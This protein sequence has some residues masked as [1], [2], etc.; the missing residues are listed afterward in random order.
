MSAAAK[1]VVLVIVGHYVPGFKA[2]GI[3]RSVENMVNH[4]HRE[5]QF[6]IVTRDRDIGD[7]APYPD[8]KQKTWNTIGNARVYYLAPGTESVSQLR[9][10]VQETAHDLIYFNSFFDPL[11]VK[12]L[13]N[14]RLGHLGRKPILLNP[15]GEFGWA[16]LSQKYPKKALFMRLAQLVGLYT[17]VRWHASSTFEAEDIMNA[18]NIPRQSIYIALDLP[19][20]TEYGTD[21]APGPVSD[22][23][24]DGIRVVFLS[25]IAPEKNLNF[26]L[27]VL[28]RVRTKV[29]FDIIGPIENTACWHECQILVRQLPT[30]VTARVLGAIKPSEVMK[31]LSEYDLLFLP[32]GGEGYGNVIAESLTTGTPVLISTNTPWRNLED[33]GLGWDLPLD[34]MDS[35]VRVVDELG[36]ARGTDYVERRKMVKENMRQFISDSSL[37]AQNRELLNV[38][39]SRI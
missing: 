26:A 35:F 21:C 24:T 17:P 27:K 23:G 22:R 3:I 9:C 36:S 28:T 12:V 14:R 13:F 8:I 15:R 4:L 29:T 19:P 39:I 16:S 18:M 10:I 7:D 32:S 34:D 11:T 20:I 30:H 5:F 2:G 6:L 1:P 33:R 25:R 37:V 38:A 31:T